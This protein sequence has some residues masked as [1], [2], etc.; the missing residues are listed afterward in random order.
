MYIDTHGD[1]NASNVDF[2]WKLQQ[3]AF[4][5]CKHTHYVQVLHDAV[6]LLKGVCYLL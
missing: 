2:V 6:G 5:T 4:I 3:N 1:W